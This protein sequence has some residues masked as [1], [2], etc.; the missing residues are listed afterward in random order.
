MTRGIAMLDLVDVDEQAQHAASEL[1][2]TIRLK[3]G[4]GPA[5]PEATRLAELL[6]SLAASDGTATV[7]VPAAGVDAGPAVGPMRAGADPS[8]VTVFPAARTVYQGSEEIP[9]TRR[10]FDL[11][12]CLA[13]NPLRVFTRA[14]LLVQVWDNEYTGPRSVDVHVLRLRAKLGMDVPLVQTLRGVGYRLHSDAKVN[15]VR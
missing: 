5:G 8:V 4:S 12:L 9:L 1:I 14:Q 3:L 11:L 10:E 15:V 13:E 6:Q 7:A 2:V